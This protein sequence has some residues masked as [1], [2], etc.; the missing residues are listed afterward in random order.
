MTFRVTCDADT[1]YK[2]RVPRDFDEAKSWV[3][4]T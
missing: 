2:V 3:L 1:D 4:L